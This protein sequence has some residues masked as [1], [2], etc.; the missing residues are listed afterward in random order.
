[1][2]AVVL[3]AVC[4]ASAQFSAG[5]LGVATPGCVSEMTEMEC[6]RPEM[7]E[8]VKEVRAAPSLDPRRIPVPRSS[9]LWASD[10]RASCELALF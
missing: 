1:M 2:M 8:L 9:L 5:R 7:D 10:V 4:H 3:W 6:G